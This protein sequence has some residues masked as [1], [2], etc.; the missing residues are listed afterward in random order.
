TVGGTLDSETLKRLPVGRN[1]TET[2]YLVPGVSSSGGVGRANPSVSGAS[3]LENSYVVDGVNITN[4]GYGG[5]G[6]YSIVFGALGSGVTTDFIKETQVKTAG[7]EAEYGESTGGVVNVVTQSGTNT[8]HGSVFGYFRPQSL[9]ASYKQLATPNGN[10][11][12][13]GHTQ[14]DF[15]V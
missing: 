12:T 5:A 13:T 11:N 15:G 6:S 1:F 10:L 7:F 2:L 14:Y 8:F 9:E 3:G 4:T